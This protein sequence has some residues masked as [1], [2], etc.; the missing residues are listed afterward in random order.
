MGSLIF[1]FLEL[2]TLYACSV[3][4]MKQEDMLVAKGKHIYD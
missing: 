1:F 4:D 3:K 2:C